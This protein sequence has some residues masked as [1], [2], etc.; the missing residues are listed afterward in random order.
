[1]L[2]AGAVLLSLPADYL[3]EGDRAERHWLART[4]RT[5][6][7]IVLIGIGVVL[8]VP[9]IPGQ[10]IL[11]IVAGLTL[12]EFPG[13]HRLITAILAR[14]TVLRAANRLRLRFKRPPFA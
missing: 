6:L 10:G 12:I 7:G 1:M 5:L 11:T 13:R 4:G 9:G 3:R 2:V 8:S 14:P